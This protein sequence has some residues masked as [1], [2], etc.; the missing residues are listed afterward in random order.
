MARGAAFPVLLP[1]EN[2]VSGVSAA[3]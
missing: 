1:G 3:A 2:Q